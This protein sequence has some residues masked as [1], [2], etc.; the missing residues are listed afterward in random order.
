MAVQPPVPP[1]SPANYY[2][3]LSPEGDAAMVSARSV[4]HGVFRPVAE[5]CEDREKKHY[6][7]TR[8][9]VRLVATPF[10]FVAAVFDVVTN[11]L[12]DFINAAVA[13][14]RGLVRSKPKEGD[15]VFEIGNIG[16]TFL[17][18]LGVDQAEMDSWAQEVNSLASTVESPASEQDL[19]AASLNR[20]LTAL[21]GGAPS[22]K[23][24]Q[25]RQQFID[26]M[27]TNTF[28][29]GNGSYGGGAPEN[30]IQ[31]WA[32]GAGLRRGGIATRRRHVVGEA[33]PEWLV[34]GGAAAL[35]GTQG[36]EVI[37]TVPGVSL[38]IPILSGRN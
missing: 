34:E 32:T 33:G 23:A 24:P 19:L 18:T 30:M 15:Q 3:S 28:S 4:V 37:A 11:L 17:Q 12:T 25:L 22:A 5:F 38:V 1:V 16:A 6:A 27:M 2:A 21:L 36:P 29:A 14:I 7:V 13:G 20:R 31:I 10:A 9:I 8:R 35:V 26:F